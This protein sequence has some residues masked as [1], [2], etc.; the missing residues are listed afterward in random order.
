MALPVVL[1]TF[2]LSLSGRIPAHRRLAKITFPLWLY[3]SVTGVIVRIMLV[4]AKVN[5]R[6]IGPSHPT[7]ADKRPAAEA[8]GPVAQSALKPADSAPR[9]QR[10]SPRHP[11]Q[12]TAPISS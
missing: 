9:P 11:F 5:E 4:A 1:I 3:V 12:T 2:Y 7:R 6:R 8:E 10:R